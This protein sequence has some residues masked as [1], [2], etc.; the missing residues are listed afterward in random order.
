MNFLRPGPLYKTLIKRLFLHPAGEFVAISRGAAI[1][2]EGK[3][4]ESICV[5]ASGSAKL[6]RNGGSGHEVLIT[7]VQ[8][9]ELLSHGAVFGE[10][11]HSRSAIALEECEVF[12]IPVDELSP[13][14]ENDPLFWR[15]LAEYGLFGQRS[16]ERG[17]EF[18][19]LCDVEE[20]IARMLE[21]L[22]PASVSDRDRWELKLSQ[23]EMARLIGAT[24]ETTSAA[25]NRLARR[26]LVQLGRCCICVPRI[27]LLRATLRA[28]ASFAA[29]S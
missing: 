16:L 14:F 10:R 23:A 1:F 19:Q 15:Y 28:E 26:G 7:V 25:L 4:S 22:V 29:R 9:G 6:I 8:G 17:I 11:R 2:S 27:T 12:D 24:R 5:L 18:F 21:N 20:R 13:E 3:Q